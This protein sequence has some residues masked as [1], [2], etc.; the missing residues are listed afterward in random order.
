[1]LPA[2]WGHKTWHLLHIITIFPKRRQEYYE[3]FFYY[4]QF[5]LPCAKCRN[6]Y[7]EHITALAIPKSKQEYALWLIQVHNRVN[8]S[9]DK[10]I[11]EETDILQEW[12]T[13]Y[14]ATQSMKDTFLIDVGEYILYGHPGYYGITEE[15]IEANLYFW[16][17]VPKLLPYTIKD[18]QKLLVYLEE[19][20]LDT[21]IV[22]S[23]TKY[24]KWFEKI[25]QLYAISKQ[26]RDEATTQCNTEC[27]LTPN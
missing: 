4:L 6:S 22:R 24:S 1:M 25:K 26:K 3:K 11:L 21:E 12:Q 16:N 18:R 20:P 14:A 13:K 17:T 10:P 7:K 9:I 27:S 5:L 23:K 8:K 2:I 19:H 15:V